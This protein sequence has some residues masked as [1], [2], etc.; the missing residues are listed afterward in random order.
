MPIQPWCVPCHIIRK[1]C[2]RTQH[3]RSR[4]PSYDWR[5]VL[6]TAIIMA[7]T[8]LSTVLLCVAVSK[9][10][11]HEGERNCQDMLAMTNSI[12]GPQC[13]SSS[14]SRILQI[15]ALSNQAQT[16]RCH[17]FQSCTC[18]SDSACNEH[19]HAVAM[20]MHM[21]WCQPS[22]GLVLYSR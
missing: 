10:G 1:A 18:T 9:G 2:R 16:E 20:S 13:C 3:V 5:T 21:Q 15:P 4:S 8:H 19:A 17:G 14:N 12:V 7:I 22:R 6:K 11:L